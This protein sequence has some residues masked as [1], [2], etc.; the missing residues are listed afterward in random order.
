MNR[1][2]L[3]DDNNEEEKEEEDDEFGN[4]EVEINQG[5]VINTQDS[6]SKGYFLELALVCLLFGIF[7]PATLLQNQNFKIDLSIV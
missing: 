3:S 6:M 4:S 7:L 5:Q 1:S 2:I